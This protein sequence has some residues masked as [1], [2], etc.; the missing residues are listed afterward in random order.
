MVSSKNEVAPDCKLAF[1]TPVK[2]RDKTA[3]Q[4]DEEDLIQAESIWENTIVGYVV[5]KCPFYHSLYA[6][7]R[8]SWSLKGTLD[9]F[10]RENG[11][12]LFKFGLEEDARKVLDGGPYLYDSRL[13]ILKQWNRNV[14]L[15]RDI[16]ASIPIWVRF[17]NLRTQFWTGRIMS[18]LASV[19]ENPI[20]MDVK[21]ATFERA[22][23][24]RV[25]VEVFADRELPSTAS[26][27]LPSGAIIEEDVVYEW[28]PPKCRKCVSF[29]HSTDQCPSKQVWVPK[30]GTSRVGSPSADAG[31]GLADGDLS[32]G[33]LTNNDHP[34]LV[35]FKEAHETIEVR[36]AGDFLALNGGEIPVESNMWKCKIRSR[37]P[38]QA[39]QFDWD[40]NA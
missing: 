8:R 37:T 2:I 23:F 29:G 10:S 33:G 13:L 19:I 12:F 28:V 11:F 3:A 26:A 5:G 21:T 27:R 30:D 16:L 4:I 6:F 34:A 25:L 15:E 31:R 32:E 17:P 24:A 35:P 38:R 22:S 9:V 1:F 7:A 20:S 36:P 14:G 18:K 39:I 40:G